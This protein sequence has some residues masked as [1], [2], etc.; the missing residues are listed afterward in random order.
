MT[1][2][3]VCTHCM[4]RC[5][6]GK[7]FCRNCGTAEQRKE[8]CRANKENNPN[9]ECRLCGI[10]KLSTALLARKLTSSIM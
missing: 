8:M 1:N 6:E 9:H 10:E 7:L 5:A 2:I 3:F 4:E